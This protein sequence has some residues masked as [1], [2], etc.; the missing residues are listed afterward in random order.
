MLVISRVLES[1]R[2][3]AGFQN[4]LFL[5]FSL[6][7]LYNKLRFFRKIMAV[8]ISVFNQLPSSKYCW[9]M[10]DQEAYI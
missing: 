8:M 10:Q 6:D 4:S 3:S 2:F 1:V 7:S 9:S 5:A